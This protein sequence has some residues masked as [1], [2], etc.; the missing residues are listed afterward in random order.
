VDI[1]KLIVK[2]TSIDTSIGSL[3]VFPFYANDIVK[4]MKSYN[5]TPD[6]EDTVS[7]YKHVVIFTSYPSELIIDDKRP[8]KNTLTLDEINKLNDQELNQIAKILIDSNV[9]TKKWLDEKEHDSNSFID[10]FVNNIRSNYSDMIERYSKFTIDPTATL[11]TQSSLY[12]QMLVDAMKKSEQLNEFLNPCHTGT[13]LGKAIESGF[14]SSNKMGDFLQNSGINTIKQMFYKPI[15]MQ[16]YEDSIKKSQELQ[17]LLD[18]SHLGNSMGNGIDSG[19]LNGGIGDA[20]KNFDDLEYKHENLN[21]TLL[22]DHKFEL[23]IIPQGTSLADVDQTLNELKENITVSC[24]IQE[25][26]AELLSAMTISQEKATGILMKSSSDNIK[27][28]KKNMWFTIIVIFLAFATGILT[29][30]GV[31]KSNPQLEQLNQNLSRIQTS[32]NDTMQNSSRENRQNF[33]L[34]QKRLFE[35]EN[36]I[37]KLK[38]SNKQLNKINIQK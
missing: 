12:S 33:E 17:E 1:S 24:Q 7:Y 3:T 29:A 14:L 11:T 25:K 21:S 19:I 16:I 23:P 5:M 26:S 28:S 2:P 27:S 8:D 32:I 31:F 15:H 9:N 4:I 20:L 30:I 38:E 35:Q 22:E 13:T 6:K 36:E 34:L 10:C 18:R 37:N